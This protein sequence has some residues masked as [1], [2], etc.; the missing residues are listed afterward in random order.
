MTPYYITNVN[1][2][3]RKKL[4]K[5]YKNS[6][7]N[8]KLLY[9]F[10]SLDVIFNIAMNDSSL[11][12]GISG[13]NN[14]EDYINRWIKNYMNAEKNPPSKREANPKSSCTDPAIKVIVKN[15]LKLSDEEAAKG[16]DTHNLFMS[17]ENI[18]G[19]LLEE[20]INTKISNLGFLWCKG[21]V[22]KAVDF[23]SEDG[24]ILLQIKNKYNTENS[25]SKTIR[26]GT[27]IKKWFRL[28]AA[29]KNNKKIPIYKWD[30]LNEIINEYLK[31]QSI[32]KK[33][34]MSESS[35]I[36]FIENISSVNK[37]LITKE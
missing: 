21:N 17:A 32:A 18:Q 4:T 10:S 11:F 14:D 1:S 6:K 31:S 8:L 2:E 22:L 15:T 33:C 12:P 24:K 7:K 9:N 16:E 5:L 20:Y 26:S 19:N 35:Y 37:K 3:T 36:N 27:T 23:C 13:V 25:A 30:E 28:G 34:D 29:T